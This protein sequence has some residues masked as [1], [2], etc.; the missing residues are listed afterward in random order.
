M[1][2]DDDIP[3]RKHVLS[4]QLHAYITVSGAL[5]VPGYYTGTVTW[6]K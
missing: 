5:Q 3:L 6:G 1:H 2:S 4:R